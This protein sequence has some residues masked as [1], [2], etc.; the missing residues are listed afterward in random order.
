M[1]VVVFGSVIRPF[2]DIAVHEGEARHS[3]RRLPNLVWP[4]VQ[5]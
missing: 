2:T 4:D 3:H 5:L 1:H